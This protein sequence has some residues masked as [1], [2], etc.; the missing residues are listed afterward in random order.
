MKRVLSEVDK[1]LNRQ[2]IIASKLNYRDNPNEELGKFLLAY[3]LEDVQDIDA[4]NIK[5]RE[6]IRNDMKERISKMNLLIVGETDFPDK[7]YFNSFD[8]IDNFFSMNE[9][10]K[11]NFEASD[12]SQLKNN[13]D[14]IFAESFHLKIP[15]PTSLANLIKDN[16]KQKF[17][18]R[19]PTMTGSELYLGHR[20]RDKYEDFEKFIYILKKESKK[21]IETGKLNQKTKLPE[22]YNFPNSMLLEINKINTTQYAKEILN[23][24][25]DEKGIFISKNDYYETINTPTSISLMELLAGKKEKQNPN[26]PNQSK[27][28]TNFELLDNS[29]KTITIQRKSS[30]IPKQK[31]ET[32]EI[33]RR[34]K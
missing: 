22:K 16:L 10:T 18:E 33:Y 21:L 1:D 14:L 7:K 4:K 20:A 29:R 17:G 34:I 12:I 32:M 27:Y 26:D 23:N 2:L 3:H 28:G 19:I 11:H 9:F 6:E 25:L 30:D 15:S 8:K 24:L 5:L 13:Y 31:I